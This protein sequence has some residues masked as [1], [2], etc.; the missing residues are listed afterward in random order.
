M[1]LGTGSRLQ[2][3]VFLLPLVF[4]KYLRAALLANS[5]FYYHARSPNTD[6]MQEVPI[7]T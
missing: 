4:G 3:R 6:V 2:S 7:Q 1:L 5:S